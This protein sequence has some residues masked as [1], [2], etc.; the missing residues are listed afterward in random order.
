MTSNDLKKISLNANKS[1]M[2]NEKPNEFFMGFMRLILK[3]PWLTLA[4]SF[5]MSVVASYYTIEKIRVDNSLEMF[6]PPESEAIKSLKEY[7]SLFGRDDLFLISASG[8]VFTV[9]FF[10]RLKAL[11]NE[12]KTIDVPLVSISDDVDNSGRDFESDPVSKHRSELLKLEDNFGFEV[13]S[14]EEEWGEEEGSVVEETTSLIS[15]RR[16]Q[17]KEGSLLIKPWFDPVPKQEEIDQLKP[18]A[19]KDPLLARR[20]INQDGTLTVLMVKVMVMSDDD[21]FKVFGVLSEVVDRHQGE[22]FHLKVTGTPAVNAALNEIVIDD[23]GSLLGYS[24]L[25]MLLAL[26]YLFRT[27]FMVVGPMAVVAVS[28]LWTMGFMAISG[29]TLN[30]LSSILP[31]FLLCVGLGDSIHLQSIFRTCRKHQVDHREALI[32]AAGITGP[33]ILFTSLTTMI[34]L[35]SFKFASVTA[36]QEMGVAGG[37][38][39]IFAL[40]HSLITLPLFLLWQG[41]RGRVIIDQ[42]NPQSKVDRIDRTLNLLVNASSTS[43][44]RTG[45]LLMGVLLLMISLVGVGQI[46]V[47]HDDLETL[48]DD[49]SI[50]SAVLEVDREL[51]GVA[52]IQIVINADALDRGIK[53][54]EVLH[55]I[56]QLTSHILEYETEEGEKIIGHALSITNVVKETR[57][58]LKGTDESYGLPSMSSSTIEDAQS[59]ASQLMSLFELQSPEQL[60]ALATIDLKA[61]HLTLQVKWQEATSYAGLIAHIDQGID[62]YF[63]SFNAKG[64]DLKPTGGVYLA[65]TIISSLLHDLVKSF[66]AAFLVI[67]F[68]MVLMLREVKLGMLA[69]IPNLFPILLMVGTLGL[70]GIPLD[71][72]T[73][74]IASIALGIAVDDTI[75]LLHHFQASYALSG[76]RERAIQDAVTHAGRAMLSTSILL[77]VGFST[78]I[79]AQTEAVQRFGLIIGATVMV[80][81]IVDLVICPAILRIAY[82]EHRLS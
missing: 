32:Q 9:D 50:K 47:W 66:S 42:I 1:Q 70:I 18:E 2:P 65:F 28:I 14:V 10:N 19:L 36:I 23:L 72:N 44:G 62:K 49:N 40:L 39:V 35:F 63:K 15:V 80:A 67:T 11:E 51:G 60:R 22:A 71:L 77:C 12:I 17:N 64:L 21:M 69:M 3:Y 37:V 79:M 27:P 4:F 25:A 52:N 29:M 13:G 59:E 26:I 45:V 43:R 6:T 75:H 5:S 7:R 55:A 56:E 46:E 30:L 48:P 68:L 24:G 74:L 33:P 34:G 81:F 20:L 76:H 54:I 53:D 58:A 78:H 8:D 73:L 41:E 82:P 38:G 31:A 57:K 16:T 61:S